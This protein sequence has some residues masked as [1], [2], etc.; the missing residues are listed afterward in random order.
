[1]ENIIKFCTEIL[2]IKFDLLGHSVSL[3][4]FFVF[5][6]LVYLFLYMIFRIVE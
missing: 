5:G 4:M 3:W 2:K 6:A 1:M